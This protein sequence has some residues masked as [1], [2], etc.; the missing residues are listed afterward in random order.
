MHGHTKRGD[1]IAWMRLLLCFMVTA[2]GYRN[3]IAGT[4]AVEKLTIDLPAHWSV[5]DMVYPP[6]NYPKHV[7]VKAYPKSVDSVAKYGVI[8][9]AFRPLKQLT[10]QCPSVDADEDVDDV[11]QVHVEEA[12]EI[13]ATAV[14]LQSLDLD[15][16][17]PG[18]S[19]EDP[20]E[21]YDR[22]DPGLKALLARKT[23]TYPH[24]KELRISAFFHADSFNS[25]LLLHKETPKSLDIRDY[26]LL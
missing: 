11:A 25:F 20:S 19:Y 16:C 18:R 9:D 1:G 23:T 3:G 24:L 15:F 5:H 17:E 22:V 21:F 6:S 12:S 8:L 10:L 4:K 7:H 13:L 2:V 26:F 14:G